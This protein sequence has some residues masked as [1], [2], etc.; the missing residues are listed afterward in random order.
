M[1]EVDDIYM[2]SLPLPEVVDVAFP[3]VPTSDIYGVLI[4]VIE[5]NIIQRD[6]ILCVKISVTAA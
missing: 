1:V 6:Y 4:D 5:N 2:I 3:F